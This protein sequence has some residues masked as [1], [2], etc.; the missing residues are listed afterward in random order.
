MIYV[1]HASY[2]GDYKLHIQFSDTREGVVDLHD[3]VYT[4]HRPIV[5]E[6]QNISLFK[7]FHIQMDT[8]VWKN[9]L[10]LAPEFL[11]ERMQ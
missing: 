6:L 4:D 9:G 1:T 3:L 2:Y 11:W 10:D 5:R 7:D 8:I